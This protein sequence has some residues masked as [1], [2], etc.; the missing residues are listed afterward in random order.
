M[1]AVQTPDA[2]GLEPI[3][4]PAD[5]DQVLAQG[6]CREA[7]ER[8]TDE[9]IDRLTQTVSGTRYGERFHTQYCT[10][11]LFATARTMVCRDSRYR[12]VRQ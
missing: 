12:H 7:V 10:K 5:L 9:C 2:L 11:H 3:D 6:V 1:K 4:R 8:L